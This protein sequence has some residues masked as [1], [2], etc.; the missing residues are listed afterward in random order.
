VV[1][2]GAA[3]FAGASPAGAAHHLVKVNEVYV[4]SAAAPGVEYVELQL[5]SAGENQVFIPPL[6]SASV[7]LYDEPGTMTAS[8]TFAAN[9]PNGQ[10]Q[11]TIL[12][13]TSGVAA[14][15]G[16]TPDLELTVGNDTAGLG[17]TACFNSGSF[18]SLDCVRWGPGSVAPVGVSPTGNPEDSIPDG[19]AIH[20]SIAAGNPTLHEFGDDTDDSAND[21]APGTPSPCPNSHTQT[22]TVCQAPSTPP[23]DTDGDGVTDDIDQCDNEQ[24]PASN[25]GCPTGGGTTDTTPP[26]QQVA[27]KRTQDV[28]KLSLTVTPDEAAT[29][30]GTGT[31]TIPGAKK[32]VRFKKVT[33]SATADQGVKLRF[34]LAKG[35]LKDVRAALEAASRKAKLKVT[36]TDAAGNKSTVR[37]TITLK[38]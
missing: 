3:F 7:S 25:N 26:T 1:V 31:V 4:G 18:G 13:G 11:R 2:A 19:Q 23:V 12:V 10:S 8:G 21:F 24:G 35:A 16:V 15:F 20:R 14:A 9:P 17:G 28:D 6:G 33:K 34:K 32:V 38:D 36:A 37:K 22:A 27:G 29:L 5:T 30:V